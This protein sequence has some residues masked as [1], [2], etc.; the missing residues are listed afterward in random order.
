MNVTARITGG[1]PEAVS[2]ARSGAPRHVADALELVGGAVAARWRAEAP[3][4]SG[5]YVGTIRHQ[6]TG[7]AVSVGS[8]HQAATSIEHGRRPGAMPPP[9]EVQILL[10]LPT[11]REAFLVAR[12]I[13]R[14]GTAGAGARERA[15]TTAAA[16]VDRCAGSALEKIGRLRP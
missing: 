4:N 12:S 14:R 1:L 11:P 2:R 16:D 3:V 13:G 5:D 7:E 10:D 15:R 6:V 8:D 9:D